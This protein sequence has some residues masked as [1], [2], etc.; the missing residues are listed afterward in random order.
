MCGRR[1]RNGG[2]CPGAL[3]TAIY[4]RY[5]KPWKAGT[6]VAVECSIAVDLSSGVSF[7]D[8]FPHTFFTH[9]RAQDPVHWHA[10]TAATPDGE[11]FWVISRHADV[12][13]VIRTPELFSS[14]SGGSRKHGGTSLKDERSAG[15]MLNQSDDP[16][17]R[18]LRG[19]VQKGFTT[20]AV[21]ALEDELR[22][23]TGLLF[24]TVA[25][26]DSFD[27]VRAV[28]RELPAQAI[29]MILGLPQADR[30]ELVDLIDRGIENTAGEIISHDT[31]REIGH[32]A[33][34]LIEQKRTNP[35]DDIFSRIVHARLDGYEPDQLDEREL[36]LFF[37]LLFPAG[38]ETTRSAL[39]GAVKAFAERPDEWQRLRNEPTLMRSAVEEVLRWTTPSVYKRRTVTEDTRF[40]GV[41]LHAGDKVTC[42]EMSA[43][44][45]ERE[46][47]QPFDFDIGREPNRHLSLG[48]GVHF[49]L[50]SQLARLEIRV[51]LEAM[52]VRFSG[53]ELAG[54]PEW[55]PNNRLVGLKYLPVRPVLA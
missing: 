39:A 3:A 38:A 16:H 11:G 23:R 21:A 43:N 14:V 7:R 52:L 46:F 18:R 35:R 29:C 32:Y 13:K 22:R 36:K 33:E 54:V 20:K 24:D 44:R 25:D 30:A 42:W 34:R 31:L 9:L 47:S 26:V 27:F 28:A 2:G 19:L 5:L 49:C 15:K 45:D 55:M 6:A 41:Q 17:H 48:A 10:P 8:G 37:N 53:F 12:V 51:V 1:L 50:G 40:N 4:S